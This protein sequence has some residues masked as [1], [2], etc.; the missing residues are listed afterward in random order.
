MAWSVRTIFLLIRGI[1][2]TGRA[3]DDPYK[4]LTMLEKQQRA[5]AR[6]SYRLLFAGAAFTAFGAMATKSLMGLA[7]KSSMGKLLMDDLRRSWG[8]F[9]N[10]LGEGIAK[11]MTPLVHWF[12][13]WIDGISQNPILMK[14]A[15]VASSI[16]AVLIALT[17]VGLVLATI[18]RYSGIKFIFP[19][20]SGLMGGGA[21]AKMLE[22]AVSS[23]NADAIAKAAGVAV[24]PLGGTASIGAGGLLLLSIPVLF[25]FGAASTILKWR[26]MTHEQQREAG[27]ELG[28]R[29]E[30]LRDRWGFTGPAAPSGVTGAEG[31]N[32]FIYDNEFPTDMDEGKLARELGYRIHEELDN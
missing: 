8:R 21:E 25:A 29:T 10:V 20:I 17:G 30:R 22:T 13:K 24:T 31:I 19:L 4:K 23:F 14:G 9:A 12:M 32:V 11:T 7:E 26:G 3:L 27:R 15:A 1:D 16:G 6:S 18:F 28:A 5:L 2:Q